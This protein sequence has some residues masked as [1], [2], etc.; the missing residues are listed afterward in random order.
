M[1]LD[2]ALAELIRRAKR[3]DRAAFGAL[4][5]RYERT[6]LAVAYARMRDSNRA[7]DVVQDA[8][9]K[10]WQ[11]LGGLEDPS[12]F[13]AWLCGIVRN[14]AIDQQRRMQ[15]APKGGVA[16]TIIDSR[17]GANPSARL[18]GQER[19]LQIDA[20]LGE[21]DEVS[22]TVV[23]LRYYE[24]L[25]SKE[26]GELLGVSAAAVDTRL[27]RARDELRL[28]LA[29]LMPEAARQRVDVTEKVN[30]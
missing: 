19:C 4:I 25:S 12:R 26:I 15:R 29:A 30:L 18:D 10:A 3:S 14:A 8:F 16:P 7:G 23:V 22:R 1:A 27:S 24:G 9:L 5:N 13:G 11:K 21:L 6:A 17:V 20:A 28:S 2:E